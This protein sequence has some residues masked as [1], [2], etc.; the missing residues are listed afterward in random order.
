MIDQ[1]AVLSGF[2]VTAQDLVGSQLST[3][4]SKESPEPAVIIARQ[5][6]P[7]PGYPF[8]QIDLGA[9]VETH[10]YLTHAGI[11]LND[12]PY[13]ETIYK[14]LIHYTVYGGN[15]ISIARELESYFRLDRIR[16]SIADLT[17]GEV[18]NTFQVIPLP[19]S[20]STEEVDVAT[21]S[22]T[23]NINDRLV[24]TATGS[25]TRI[26]IDGDLYPTKGATNPLPLSVDEVSIKYPNG[27]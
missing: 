13:F 10:G 4:G 12:E 26:V 25:F 1:N 7:E 5:N 17:G 2:V 23:F 16:D 18:E 6:G 27:D 15:A 8:I 14:Y 3:V 21:F 24:D 9:T 11:D 22:I 20:N 19:K